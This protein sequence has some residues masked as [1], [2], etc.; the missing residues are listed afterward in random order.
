M[1]SIRKVTVFAAFALLTP[2]LL[3]PELR[4]GDWPQFRGPQGLAVA[5][6]P[7]PKAI[8]PDGPQVLW[9]G[10]VPSGHS[11]P[12][13]S[14]GRIFLTGFE[15]LPTIVALDQNNGTQLWK[16][17]FEGTSPPS[18]FHPDAAA[19]MPT[20]VTDGE[21][22][23]AYFGNYGIVALDFDGELIWERRMDHPTTSQFGVG[24]SPL[25]LDGQVIV[26]RDG[27]REAAIVALDILD[28]TEL[29]RLDRFEYGQA[30]STPFLWRNASRDELVIAGTNKLCAYD[31]GNGEQLWFV[32]GLTSMPCTTPTGDENTLYYAAWSTPNSRGRSFWEGGFARSLELSDAEIADPSLLFD[33][34]DM[35]SDGKVVREEVPECRAKDAFEF[36]DR[37]LDGSWDRDELLTAE[38]NQGAPGKNLMVAVERGA[39]GD[40]S[41]KNVRWT[42][43]RGLPYVSSPLLYRDRIWLFKSGGI[44]TCLDAHTGEAILDRV[45]LADRGEYYMSPVGAAG[46]V[47]IGSAEGTLFV[48]DAETDELVVHQTATF[49]EGLFATP[50]ILDGRI[51]VRTD[52]TLWAFGGSPQDQ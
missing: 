7:L 6:S 12:C 14:G 39:S 27:A 16:R 28:G 20:A 13:I 2:T 51:Y 21:T 1:K 38:S 43:S 23:V 18:Y 10:K 41:K 44:V 45:R 37:D 29:W 19:A 31:P 17:S 47:L 36:L 3:V 25:L 11:S 35:N 46:R 42:R 34:L 24:S 15:D 5:H 49:E 30:H 26:S 9:Q 52:S 22:V 4:G 50:A 40:S 33:R 8:D 48:L 32:D